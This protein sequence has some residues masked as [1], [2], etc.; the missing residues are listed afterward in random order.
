MDS[1][2]RSELHYDVKGEVQKQIADKNRNQI[3]GEIIQRPTIANE[4]PVDRI[5]DHDKKESVRIGGSV[6]SNYVKPNH[7]PDSLENA[8]VQLPPSHI[9]YLGRQRQRRRH[10]KDAVDDVEWGG[11]VKDAEKSEQNHHGER[12]QGGVGTGI[13]IRMPRLVNLQHLKAGEHVHVRRVE[14][15]IRLVGANM[16]AGRHD[17]FHDEPEA[18]GI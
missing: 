18:Q 6:A 8:P 11:G 4:R 13:D 15:E 14:L 17:P 1:L 12:E 2:P 9:I 5:S 7:V 3:S 10:V 16:I